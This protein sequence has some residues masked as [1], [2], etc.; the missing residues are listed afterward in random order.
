MK[1]V[2]YSAVFLLTANTVAFAQVPAAP[3]PAPDT[4]PMPAIQVVPQLAP[5]E[6]DLPGPENFIVAPE[7]E[8]FSPS[9]NGAGPM[10]PFFRMPTNQYTGWYRPRAAERDTAVRCQPAD[11]RPRGFGNLFARTPGGRRLDYRPYS[12]S[13]WRSPYGP[14]YYELAPDQRCEGCHSKGRSGLFGNGTCGTC[15]HAGGDCNCDDG[16]IC[17]GL[18]D[19]L[20][21]GRGLGW[22]AGS[23]TCRSGMKVFTITS[24]RRAE[25]ADGSCGAGDSRTTR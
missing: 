23:G 18:F 2:I 21:F 1:R 20:A 16:G 10:A 25:C 3:A 9:S 14:A 12:L 11:F 7:I 24:R 5:A 6:G 17:G 19:K 15:G 13:D 4:A 8:V 22:N